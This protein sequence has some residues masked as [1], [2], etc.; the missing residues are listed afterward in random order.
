MRQ[1]TKGD[2][3]ALLE[4]HKRELLRHPDDCVMCALSEQRDPELVVKQDADGVVMLD[5]FGNRHAHLL[6]ISRRHVEHTTELSW[7]EYRALQRLAYEA[8]QALDKVV[9]PQRVFIAALGS[10]APQPMTFSHFH[11]HVVPVPKGDERCRPAQVF[12]WTEGVVTYDAEQAAELV[13]R[14]KSAWPTRAS[15]DADAPPLVG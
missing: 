3:L 14:L 6:V 4:Q 1:L 13:A 15:T 2:A 7:P 12:S 5:R 9:Q 8:S 11:L 10:H